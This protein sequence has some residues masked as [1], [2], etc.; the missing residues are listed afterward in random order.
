MGCLNITVFAEHCR[1]L[2]GLSKMVLAKVIA[3]TFL[4]IL[5]NL[6]SMQKCLL[7]K[8]VGVGK[9]TKSVQCELSETISS[10]VK[11]Y[12]ELEIKSV[13]SFIKTYFYRKRDCTKCVNMR[14]PFMLVMATY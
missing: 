14:K 9:V 2:Y 6:A 13:A 11:I 4:K 10:F 12:L 7:E 8:T 3:F 1:C 5:H